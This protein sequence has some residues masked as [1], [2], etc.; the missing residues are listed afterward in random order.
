MSG[1]VNYAIIVIDD[2]ESRVCYASKYYSFCL[3][4]AKNVKQMSSVTMK[5]F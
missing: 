1:P 5:K 4:D 2:L 3:I